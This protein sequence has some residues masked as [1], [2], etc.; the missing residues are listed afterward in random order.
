MTVTTN[1][2]MSMRL[3]VD[4]I[5]SA[6]LY[7]DE[8]YT[9]RNGIYALVSPEEC[10][11]AVAAHIERNPQLL[12]DGR[13][14]P[15]PWLLSAV[16]AFIKSGLR[17]V[18]HVPWNTFIEESARR[19]HGP[20]I[21]VPAG[22]LKLSDFVPVHER[23]LPQTSD[24]WSRVQLAV[25][26]D[27][28]ASC[29]K[30]Q[31][32]LQRT[33]ASDHA[34]IDLL[35]EMFGYALWPTCEFETFFVLFGPSN[36][37]KSLILKTLIALVGSNNVAS[38]PLYKLSD[39]FSL[40]EIDGKLANVVTE[41]SFEKKIDT[42]LLK[43]LV[44]G[45]RVTVERKYHP[46]Q[47]IPLTAKFVMGT[48][49]FPVLRDESGGIWRRLCPIPCPHVVP[50]ADRNRN[51]FNELM[52][53]SPG[54]LAWAVLG[55]ARLLR[56]QRFTCCQSSTA[57]IAKSR[58]ASNPIAQFIEEKC[59]LV[60]GGLCNRQHLFNVYCEWTHT[61]KF[62][63]INRSEFYR[64]VELIVAQ[65]VRPRREGRGG[66][67]CFCD[68]SLNDAPHPAQTTPISDGAVI[69][70]RNILQERQ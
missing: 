56:N 2:A 5:R 45:E 6:V 38:F 41:E 16:L 25:T 68:I 61:N 19:E 43:A 22:I 29:P 54:I 1:I 21:C 28:T 30:W 70:R 44:S 65:P 46:P 42:T 52:E 34:C 48:N 36:S 37:G 64:S 60:R 51:L 53:E 9:W 7:R 47:S 18:S 4:W 10:V 63:Q 59:L 57:Q 49:E 3:E 66:P 33:F 39:R 27:F 15:A 62:R 17:D 13:T 50:E 11:R 26:P 23:L 35:A 67:R 12:G 32:F 40:G 69:H 8:I 31:S 20:C 14:E 24:F 55:L 58:L